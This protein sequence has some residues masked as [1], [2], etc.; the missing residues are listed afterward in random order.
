[1][2]FEKICYECYFAPHQ[3]K[4]WDKEVQRQW[5][6]LNDKND[7]LAS[8][9]ELFLPEALCVDHRLYPHV[10]VDL[11]TCDCILGSVLVLLS[12]YEIST[13]PQ[14]PRILE[15]F[16]SLQPPKD[17]TFV[18]CHL[19]EGISTGACPVLGLKI[20]G[21]TEADMF[22]EDRILLSVKPAKYGAGLI[23]KGLRFAL[24]NWNLNKGDTGTATLIYN[25]SLF[26]WRVIAPF[27]STEDLNW[28]LDPL[29]GFSEALAQ[30]EDTDLE[31]RIFLY[32][33]II[34]VASRSNCVAKTAEG[35]ESQVILHQVLVKGL[36]LAQA[37]GSPCFVDILRV[38]LQYRDASEDLKR[39]LKELS[40]HS[41]LIPALDKLDA[42]AAD[43]ASLGSEMLRKQLDEMMALTASTKPGKQMHSR[44]FTILLE[45]ILLRIS[46]LAIRSRFF[47]LADRSLF[48]LEGVAS[49]QV[50][51]LS[52]YLQAKRLAVENNLYDDVPLLRKTVN[53]RMDALHMIRE[54]TVKALQQHQSYLVDSGTLHTEFSLADHSLL[55][56]VR[57]HGDLESDATLASG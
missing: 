55:S 7:P 16:Y 27:M 4:S 50:P 24:T 52:R 21:D 30:T 10:Y 19:A 12:Q 31:W 20:E 22:P 37:S 49:E 43:P 9:L 2:D 38:A 15:R 14:L 26:L 36:N 6:L 13:H 35:L 25:A 17:S 54:G 47:E 1:M 33:E 18:K 51:V 32:R 42:V 48:H 41:D 45:A 53:L 57:L 5:S 34:R 23:V 44:C 11:H 40:T 46:N 39:I 28:I 29:F 3:A 56:H 8:I